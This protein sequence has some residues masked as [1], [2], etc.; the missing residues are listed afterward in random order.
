MLPPMFCGCKLA[1]LLLAGCSL[2]S[3]MAGVAS[4]PRVPHGPG[5]L[6][7]GTDAD[8]VGARLCAAV[9]SAVGCGGDLGALGS[10]KSVREA[11]PGLCAAPRVQSGRRRLSQNCS[12]DLAQRIVDLSC[13]DSSNEL[14]EGEYDA[15]QGCV[16]ECMA[17]EA[18]LPL[19]MAVLTTVVLVCCS[20]FCSGLTLGL[21]GLDMT[22]LTVLLESGT[23]QDKINATKIAPLRSTG[24][25]LLCVLLITNT[26]VNAGLAI[27]MA[28]F[29]GGFSGFLLSTL[30]IMIFGEITPQAICS[31][32]GLA[33]GAFLYPVIWLVCAIFY[34]LAYPIAQVL[35]AVLGEEI[36]LSYSRDE[37]IALLSMHSVSH[38]PK[39]P[40]TSAL[41][42]D[43]RHLPTM[44]CLCT[45]W[46]THEA[47][48]ARRYS[49]H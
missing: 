10:A 36:G 46:R 9:V 18:P 26:A 16:D 47:G 43:P 8:Q 37:L 28:G 5:A 33:I 14:F 3:L 13:I 17:S 12:V 22:M 1:P 6:G 29:T 38:P 7:V 49:R 44:A 15:K 39:A 32:H 27:V 11:C 25:R 23:E 48:A 40:A 2:L 45:G 34:P 30:L 35:D 42:E 4:S 31:R 24:N 21:M 19:P 20:A 41:Q